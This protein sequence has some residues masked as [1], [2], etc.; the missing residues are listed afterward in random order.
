ML[1]RNLKKPCVFAVLLVI[2]WSPM[3]IWAMTCPQ[4][5]QGLPRA[6]SVKVLMQSNTLKRNVES[7]G[8]YI[9]ETYPDTKFQTD[10]EIPKTFYKA[11]FEKALGHLDHIES[12]LRTDI[13]SPNSAYLNYKDEIENLVLPRYQVIK[14]KIKQQFFT[15]KPRSLLSFNFLSPP[16]EETITIGQVFELANEVADLMNYQPT[17]VLLD[18]LKFRTNQL[19]PD[20]MNIVIEGPIADKLNNPSLNPY[21][22]LR[23]FLHDNSAMERLLPYRVLG[24]FHD[25]KENQNP[26]KTFTTPL[27]PI[28]FNESN[29]IPY[30]SWAQPSEW[31]QIIARANRTHVYSYEFQPA[32]VDG[33]YFYLP[34][35]SPKHDDDHLFTGTK[36]DDLPGSARTPTDRFKPWLM[37]FR[38]FVS[39]LES[40][41]LSNDYT[42]LER[43]AVIHLYGILSHELVVDHR[44]V[45]TRSGNTWVESKFI[46]T[47]M[48]SYSA[49]SFASKSKLYGERRVLNNRE[50]ELSRMGIDLLSDI[51]RQFYTAYPNLAP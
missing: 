38:V 3:T 45:L 21:Q 47:Y 30:L 41:L 32:L 13:E 51:I 23:E 28:T 10:T 9:E 4:V 49:L 25:L 40:K 22:V 35:M 34:S 46:K 20:R 14:E 5:F 1:S 11:F 18:F 48:E 42:D 33:E 2:F 37:Q 7:L 17:E 26:H 15:P 6:S 16:T 12:N 39:Y 50:E 29:Y 43:Y 36:Y 31:T 8:R 19:N 44:R 24:V 27:M